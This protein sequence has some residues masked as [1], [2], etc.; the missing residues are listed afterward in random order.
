MPDKVKTHSKDDSDRKR[1]PDSEGGD[2][3]AKSHSDKKKKYGGDKK[4]KGKNPV[5]QSHKEQKELKMKRKEEENPNHALVVKLKEL[6]EGLR[7]KAGT[8]EMRA[9]TVDEIL[10]LI[11]GKAKEVIF[12]HDSARIIQSAIK[13][14]TMEQRARIFEQVKGE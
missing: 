3:S 10:E 13:Y 2:D 14:G 12:Q 9:K 7:V 6:W 1:K 8:A 11:D 4:E 5:P